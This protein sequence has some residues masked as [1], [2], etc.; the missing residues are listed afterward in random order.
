VAELPL[1]LPRP[2]PDD[3]LSADT[4]RLDG[5]LLRYVLLHRSRLN[6]LRLDRQIRALVDGQGIVNLPPGSSRSDMA[7]RAEATMQLAVE[8]A[9]AR[10]AVARWIGRDALRRQRATDAAYYASECWLAG[11]QPD[12]EPG[13]HFLWPAPSHPTHRA[14]LP[15]NSGVILETPFW[16]YLVERS[17]LQEEHVRA[18][19][20]S[21]AALHPGELDLAHLLA[22]GERLQSIAADVVWLLG[23][24]MNR[25]AWRFCAEEA[26]L[27][28]RLRTPPPEVFD[29][30]LTGAD[31]LVRPKP[32]R[33]GLSWAL[34][35]D[36]EPA[37]P[38]ARGEVEGTQALDEIRKNIDRWHHQLGQQLAVE[39]NIQPFVLLS[40]RLGMIP[41]TP[42][43]P[44][45]D[46]AMRSLSAAASQYEQL[47][48]SPQPSPAA[49]PEVAL[50]TESRLVR[51]FGSL[52]D[53]QE[54]QL[55]V[56]LAAGAFLGALKEAEGAGQDSAPDT[57]SRRLGLELLAE[58]LRF[59]ETDSEG[60]AG[61]LEGL[62]GA[63]I[64]E[65]AALELPPQPDLIGA[66]VPFVQQLPTVIQ[67]AELAGAAWRRRGLR[68]VIARAW[69]AARIRLVQFCRD[70]RVGD[71]NLPELICAARRE[72]PARWV[73]IDPRRMTL[74]S[75]SR[76]W[77][78]SI[79]HDEVPAWL[80]VIALQRLGVNA[81]RAAEQERLLR[82][83]KRA[84]DDK[85]AKVN[86]AAPRMEVPTG[87]VELCA[88][89]EGA[90]RR[91]GLGGGA[92]ILLRADPSAV[93]S[94]W[95]RAG[96]R[97]VV[98]LLSAS[99]LRLLG[100]FHPDSLRALPRPCA[101]WRE[102][103]AVETRA[104]VRLSAELRDI[105]SGLPTWRRLLRQAALLPT[106]VT[107]EPGMALASLA[108][109]DELFG[110][111]MTDE[112]AG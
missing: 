66:D 110:S 38:G 96:S 101:L 73:T 45:V 72:G 15:H 7:L 78:A 4:S 40:D 84:E 56:A 82:A 24:S 104:F 29:A 91:G 10:P 39:G 97:G 12:T 36:G 108:G 22:D 106:P 112:V 90:W 47:R 31:A 59:R 17:R 51:L 103:G 21:E 3:D 57:T 111:A 71:A 50:Q 68:D 16:R 54:K 83:L 14:A 49:T 79:V 30:L 85:A 2:Q 76:V 69:Y 87:L 100:D 9:L 43:W 102:E 64:A 55:A 70:G 52:L 6:M 67:R 27:D 35:P 23:E 18:G 46:S 32:G 62:R 74:A 5:S 89:G 42:A 8:I 77:M 53:A 105:Q 99:E 20:E 63:V 93:A 26:G 34:T 60:I 61:K 86:A 107:G 65:Q 109:P 58:G 13:A 75:W 19:D 25:Q 37:W 28:G 33:P 11:E 94:T 41:T 92:A 48:Q 44:D 81:L 98:L 1:P 95:L 80:G 88:R